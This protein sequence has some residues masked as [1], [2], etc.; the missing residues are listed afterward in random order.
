M[1]CAT[2]GCDNPGNL[3]FCQECGQRLGPRV[4]APTPAVG[5]G[6]VPLAPS[7]V[8]ATVPQPVAPPPPVPATVTCAR[9]G[10]ANQGGIRYCV[11]CGNALGAPPTAPAA[12][13]PVRSPEPVVA[14]PRA[15]PPAAPQPAVAAAPDAARICP[16]CRGTA[17]EGAQFCRFCGAALGA[18][19]PAAPAVPSPT[20]GPALSPAPEPHTATF[21]RPPV[22][23]AF[24]SP[25]P[26]IPVA[27]SPAP[28]Q[29]APV[30]AARANA[31]PAPPPAPV[32]RPTP[33][34]F[35]SPSAGLYEVRPTGPPA[36][37][38]PAGRIVVITREGAEG[39]SYPFTEQ[40]DLGRLEGDVRIGEDAYLSPRH[41]RIARRISASGAGAGSGKAPSFVLIDL[42]STNGVYLR[43]DREG[44]R[45]T[46]L[47]DQDLF[48][49]GQQVLK[50]EVVRD[51]E[52]GLAPAAQHG[53][54]VFGTPAVP[55]YARIG[56]R[57]V[58]GV[59]RDV[60]HVQKA[61]TVLGRESGD[62]VFTDDP[63]LSRRHAAI[64]FDK[65]A[66]RFVLSDLGSS[67][68]T[69]IRIR[70]EVTI[71]SGDQFR[72]GQQLFRVDLS[73]ASAP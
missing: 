23:I 37:T 68:G 38:P 14:A 54:L 24:P 20:P 3:V 60:F 29:V 35:A 53:T 47:E 72:V 8:A 51:A 2:C 34:P 66:R 63:F 36:A 59:T 62:I 13:S 15:P 9:C 4:A 46:T 73:A 19:A 31:S 45:E 33:G 70:G 6:I 1:I 39:A 17:D 12:A 52:E 28:I 64:T 57:S 32:P 58:E 5:M 71:K 44:G 48:L 69:F 25:A 61:E 30:P 27:A 55:R 11:T 22:P 7:P 50:F 65:G 16:R 41:A 56:Q 67:N 26:S 49:V 43:L 40:L 10:G 18:P 42:S 21:G